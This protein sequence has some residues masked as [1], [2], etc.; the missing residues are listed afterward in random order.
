M[1]LVMK[2]LVM[3]LIGKEGFMVTDGLGRQRRTQYKAIP[4]KKL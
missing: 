1:K 2:V 3:G 4:L